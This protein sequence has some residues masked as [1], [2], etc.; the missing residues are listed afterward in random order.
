MEKEIIKV[1]ELQKIIH[2]NDSDIP[3]LKGRQDLPHLGRKVLKPLL[4]YESGELNFE[5]LKL[6]TIYTFIKQEDISLNTDERIEKVFNLIKLNHNN[7]DDTFISLVVKNNNK[8]YINSEELYNNLSME[9]CI[10]VLKQLCPLE[11]EAFYSNEDILN[12]SLRR[13]SL[14][15]NS[16]PITEEKLIIEDINNYDYSN[17]LD[18]IYKVY[19]Q[20]DKG[21]FALQHPTGNGKTYFLEKFLLNSI[22]ENFENLKNH[23]KIIVLTSSKVNVNEIYRNIEKGLK[24]KKQLE[25]MN[26]VFQM[27]SIMDILS[28][29]NFLREILI[30]LNKSL[31][32]Y[33]KFPFNFLRDLQNEIKNLMRY[34]EQNALRNNDFDNIVG[35]YLP[36]IKKQMFRYYRLSLK[37][38]KTLEEIEELKKIKLPKFLEKLYPMICAENMDKKIFIM[39]TDKFLYGYVGRTE[40]NFFYQEDENLI[41]IDEIDSCKE[42]FLKY[43]ENTKTLTMNNIINTFN[44]RYNSFTEKSNN[45]ISNLFERLR[46]EEKKVIEKIKNSENEDNKKRLNDIII[47]RK[48]IKNKLNKYRKKGRDLRKDYAT[49]QKYYEML[50]K[51][52]IFLF[53]DENHYFTSFGQ[54]FYVDINEKNALINNKKT[55]LS[56][57]RMLKKLFYYSYI[58]F[59]YLLIDIYNYH[60][61]VR[62]EQ[63]LE[64][65]I[66]SHFI[67]NLDIQ[68]QL[69]DEFKNFFV[70]RT[71]LTNTSK[72]KK[73]FKGAKEENLNL[74]NCCF[75][76]EEDNP[77]Y[78]LNRKVIISTQMVYLTPEILLYSITSRNMVFGISATAMQETCIG[79]FDLKWLRSKLGGKYYLLSYEEEEKLRES[80]LKIN[81]FENKIERKLNIFG[82]DCVIKSGFDNIVAFEKNKKLKNWLRNILGTAFKNENYRED[83]E[84]VQRRYFEYSTKVFLN[85]LLEEKSSSLL[86]IN[87]RLTQRDMLKEVV[88]N[89]SDFLEKEKFLNKKVYF[90][91]LNSKMLNN[92]FENKE[93]VDNELMNN[94]KNPDVKTIIFTTYQSA[95]TGVNIKF[96]KENFDKKHLVELDKTLQKEMKISLDFKDIDEIAIE[97]K[98]HLINFNENRKYTL[99]DMMYYSNLMVDNKIITK[100]ARSYLLKLADEKLF[101]R[102]YKMSYDYS[103]NAMG[104]IIQA[105]GR[106][107]RTKSRNKFRNIYFDEDTCKIFEKFEPR[108]RLFNEDINFALKEIKKNKSEKENPKIVEFII[109]E[110]KKI[111]QY[112]K[113][114]FLENIA[115]YNREIK[116]LPEGEE[117]EGIKEDL[118]HL[119]KIYDDFRRAVVLNPTRSEQTIKN[120]CY[121]SIGKKIKEY[122]V[123]EEAP[124]VIKNIIFD[125]INNNVSLAESRVKEISEIPLLRRFCKNNIGLFEENDEIILPYIYQ[126]IFKGMIGELVIKEIFRQ[127]EIKL[128]SKEFL[129]ERGLFEVFDDVTENGFWLDY[130]NYNLDKPESFLAFNKW[131]LNGANNKK[132]LVNKTNKLFFINLISSSVKN[133]GQKIE[134]FKIKDIVEEIKKTCPYEECEVVVV[135]GI[136]KYGQDKKSLEIDNTVIIE[137]QRLLGGKDEK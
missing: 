8:I 11:E 136:L 137:L 34:I 66:V 111:Q 62:P 64:K 10:K 13:N 73:L 35:L 99:I 47:L 130:K 31:Y 95:G 81:S 132:S 103:E 86:F 61:L 120:P 54:R 53:E 85:F 18:Y 36:V 71:M 17:I 116:Y 94:L 101:T 82:N 39:T 67:F 87:N 123:I 29:I 38:E 59:N 65:E 23:K 125:S 37:K 15:D 68:K 117:K 22:L 20:K 1:K 78:K 118:T 109:C 25:K 113:R 105:I 14:E 77:P 56:L 100:M 98:T 6:F 19:S 51:E 50:K 26:C 63:E 43:I 49:T 41:F 91:D 9:T 131:I 55:N 44:E 96:S 57:D 75:Q 107:N 30:E 28:D 76:I 84:E 70:E 79:N 21:Y 106:V 74:K 80:L 128:K 133:S 104:K 42:N 58:D 2:L 16:F 24:R 135:S 121:F 33:T 92:F 93:E 108:N 134:F 110:D 52:R 46:E 124:E 32:F 112:F 97:N 115:D 102:L 129:I 114:T 122:K 88:K 27:K 4:S 69:T 127:Y 60:L 72:M 40:T 119:A 48:K 45:S 89:L 3:R 7:V 83:E 5:D 12:L 126:A 90:K